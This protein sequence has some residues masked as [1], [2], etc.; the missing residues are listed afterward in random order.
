MTSG[1]T[2][3]EAA[4]RSGL[5]AH[6]LRYYERI[7]LLEPPLRAGSGHRRYTQADLDRLVFLTRLRATGMPIGTML[8]FAE[9]V[10]RGPHTKPERLALLA[11][12]RA[13]V[14]ERIA[15]LQADLGV[16]DHKIALYQEQESRA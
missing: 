9:L 13:A 3:R 12:H 7:G 14:A 16:I 5:T 11:E 6:T 10:R 8:R 4:Q 15:R 2:I 1:L